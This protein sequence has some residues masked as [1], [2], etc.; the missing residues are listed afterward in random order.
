MTPTTKSYLIA[1]QQYMYKDVEGYG[2][3]SYPNRELSKQIN[4]SESSIRKCNK[5]LEYNDYLSIVKNKSV[6]LETGFNTET[7]LYKLKEIGQAIIW[8]LKNHEDKINQNSSDI[9]Q[10]K[11]EIDLLKQQLKSQQE[12]L[13]KLLKND[14]KRESFS[15]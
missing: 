10:N 6:D 1:A 3:I 5:E 13:D 11:E 2:K 4:M 9:I 7:K 8:T 14:N 12:L 15:I